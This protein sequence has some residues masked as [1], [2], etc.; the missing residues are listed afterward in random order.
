MEKTLREAIAQAGPRCDLVSIF[1]RC[2]RIGRIYSNC[3]L[4]GSSRDPKRHCAY[5][6]LVARGGR[7]V[8]LG[9][10]PAGGG[11]GGGTR[12]GGG[13]GG[14]TRIGGGAGG[15]TRIG[16]GAGGG[17]PI[18]G[19]TFPRGDLRFDDLAVPLLFVA[20]RLAPEDGFLAAISANELYSPTSSSGT[21]KTIEANSSSSIGSPKS[22]NTFEIA[23][24]DSRRK[25]L[26]I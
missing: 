5:F 9:G 16:G 18:G 2:K 8:F 11:A 20:G 23:A 4:A 6:F 22:R 10:L 7:P 13:A 3:V 15:G 19:G 1:V 26:F 17:T 25:R 21:A 24:S 12:I 14:G